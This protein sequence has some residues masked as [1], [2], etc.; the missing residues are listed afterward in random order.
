MRLL[1]GQLGVYGGAWGAIWGSD[2][3]QTVIHQGIAI[4]EEAA[5]EAPRA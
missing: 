5:L 4:H 3:L 1:R 2:A